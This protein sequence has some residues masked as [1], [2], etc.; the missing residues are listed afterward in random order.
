MTNSKNENELDDNSELQ[1]HNRELSDSQSNKNS[2]PKSEIKIV[3]QS[4]S[5]GD[6]TPVDSEQQH[7]EKSV[8][9][10]GKV[11]DEVNNVI[12]TGEEQ[13]DESTAEKDS[14]D[15]P[16]QNKADHIS[17]KAEDKNNSS[18]S[19]YQISLVNEDELSVV[20][21][22]SRSVEIES[23]SN[24]EG[25]P[26]NQKLLISK[27]RDNNT[28]SIEIRIKILRDDSGDPV[29][30]IPTEPGILIPNPEVADLIEK[31]NMKPV[32]KTEDMIIAE[33]IGKDSP[34][35][36]FKKIYEKNFRIGLIGSI[37]VY[38]I[39]VIGFA[40]YGKSKS[41]PTSDDIVTRLIVIEDVPA[42][43]NLQNAEDPGK[44]PEEET[45]NTEVKEKII[46]RRI[47]IR[48]NRITPRTYNNI[49]EDISKVDTTSVDT[50]TG[51]N[52]TAIDTTGSG[53]TASGRDTTGGLELEFAE[54]EIGL[55]FN[56]P[57][58]WNIIPVSEIDKNKK[59]YEGLIVADT[60]LNPG[61]LNIFINVDS[62]DIAFSR[63]KFEEVFEMDND[64]IVAYKSQPFVN[65]EDTSYE[66]YMLFPEHTL[67]IR[68]SIRQKYYDQ[69][70][71]LID[72]SIKSINIQLPDTKTSTP[73]GS[74]TSPQN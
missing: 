26:L 67:H 23:N 8:P 74:G 43:V 58:N 5:H 15:K 51:K 6:K 56:Y 70:K 30:D 16:E 10:P 65:G 57:V 28:R 72:K 39:A 18:G 33:K 52:L 47:P 42:K 59:P 12:D 35:Q 54:N 20:V 64:S 50:T 21:N 32:V 40:A 24:D 9:E 22:T 14:T 4:E 60:T 46:P 62:K 27:G 73:T 48:R 13:I 66:Y 44:P 63:E 71:M 49:S 45:E 37:I 19:N 36:K 68:V 69:M 3:E 31:D 38:L 34:H 1:P 25:S 53:D 41:N 11:S 29:I 7:N 17:D 2:P 61:D 55:K